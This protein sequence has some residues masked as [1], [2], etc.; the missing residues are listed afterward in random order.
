MDVVEKKFAAG[1]ALR[2]A[3]GEQ[4]L[5]V[6]EGNGGFRR[7]LADEGVQA[8]IRAQAEGVRIAGAGEEGGG[9]GGLVVGEGQARGPEEGLGMGGVAADDVGIE[10]GRFGQ[11]GGGFGGDGRPHHLA[12]LLGGGF[13]VQITGQ[14]GGAVAQVDGHGA[15]DDHR[16]GGPGLVQD[17]AEILA[18]G[19]VGAFQA[20]IVGR[21]P[22]F[23]GDG[24][25]AAP[26]VEVDARR[27]QPVE[28]ERTELGDMRARE[29]D[30]QAGDAGTVVEPAEGGRGTVGPGDFLVADHDD[31]RLGLQAFEVAGHFAQDM[32]IAAVER[33]LVHFDRM[34]GIAAAQHQLQLAADAE[35]GI[36]VAAGGRTAQQADAQGARGRVFERHDRHRR[37]GQAGRDEAIG[38]ELVVD[39][40]RLAVGLPVH[41]EPGGMA[42]QEPGAG[43]FQQEKQDDQ[44]GRRKGQ[45]P[46]Q[47]QEKRR[48]RGQFAMDGWRIHDLQVARL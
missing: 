45:P 41:E 13:V 39:P 1:N 35:G 46:A 32:G 33:H 47:A 12:D 5:G 9:F 4:R 11:V 25:L 15:G 20:R 44:G 26:G 7:A 21:H 24:F 10:A 6:Q 8:G 34:V 38:E 31:D 36:G 17:G 22:A 42:G 16:R 14:E 19:T 37:L 2:G 30:Q 3:E 43:Q 28:Q 40:G 29:Q 48:K 27:R 18:V 23:E